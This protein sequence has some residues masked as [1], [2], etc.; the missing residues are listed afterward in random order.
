MINLPI[1]TKRE[2]EIIN[3]KN[4]GY[5]LAVAEKDYFLALVSKIIFDSPL[6]KKLVFKGGTALHH[7]YLPQLRFSED[8]DFTSLD[9]NIAL[10][11]IKSVFS[12]YD[13]LAIK[14]EYVSESTIKVERLQYTGPLGLANSLKIEIDYTQNVALPAK[15]MVYKNIWKIPA[16]VRVMDKREI[17]AEKIRAASDRARYRDFYD[18]VLLFRNYQFDMR[19]IAELIRRKEI[20]QPIEKKAILANWRFVQK[21]RE[22]EARIVYYAENISQR[23]IKEMLEKL[24]FDIIK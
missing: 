8:L 11:E 3:R 24:P 12:P 22:Q 15:N 9:K 13:F 20:R 6:R 7:C 2:L 1:L 17:C 14:K 19:E 4:F 18:L 23:E 5:P 10:E 16:K 21:D